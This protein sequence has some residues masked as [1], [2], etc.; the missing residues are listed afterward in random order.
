[1]WFVSDNGKCNLNWIHKDYIVFS[2][3]PGRPKFDKSD[4]ILIHL[5]DHSLKI[6]LI[7]DMLDVI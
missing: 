1:M 6:E 2:G 7:A 4:K 3:A 5:I